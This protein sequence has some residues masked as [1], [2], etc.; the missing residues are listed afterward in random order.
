MDWVKY[1]KRIDVGVKLKKN[2]D[3]I[4]DSDNIIIVQICKNFKNTE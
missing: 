2:S 1:C 4:L 3:R